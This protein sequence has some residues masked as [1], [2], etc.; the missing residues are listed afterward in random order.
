[1][2]WSVALG[3]LGVA[4]LGC[5]GPQED[6]ATAMESG[7]TADRMNQMIPLLEQGLPI[8]GVS[9]PAY[10]VNARRGAAADEP[11][12]EQP[13]L[14]VAAR[15]MMAYERGDY[16]W[17]NYSPTSAEQYRAFMAAIVAAGGS[18]RS[19]PFAAKIPIM[20]DDPEGTT[21]RMI[22]QLN[23]GQVMVV[24]QEVETVEELE[25]AVAGMRF[26]SKGGIRPEQ[27]FE[28]AAAYWGMSESEY[29][30]KADVWPLNPNGEL[31]IN[32]I[33]ESVGGVANAAAIAAHPAVAV[34]SAGAGTMGRVYSSTNADGETVRDDASFDAAVA[35]ILAA[36]KAANKSCAYPVNNSAEVES[37]MADG[38]DFF[39]L[40]S[41]NQD[42]FDAVEAGHRIA[43]RPQH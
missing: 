3:V 2:R 36:C 13:D 24:M 9:H 14:A 11:P 40:Q 38:W 35:Q 1:M 23:D 21:A 7:Q 42:A 15:E 33:I 8:F 16:E 17:N 32:V 27:G 18:A 43:G 26:A 19:H 4:V 37:F 6:Q 5:G 10:V 29:L 28:R 12:P 25:Q 20:H 34:V 22:D 41:R 30:E 39:I 31:L